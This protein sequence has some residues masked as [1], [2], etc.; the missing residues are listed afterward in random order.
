MG[1]ALTGGIRLSGWDSFQSARL[2][3]PGSTGACGQNFPGHD[4]LE[5]CVVPE[6]TGQVAGRERW[7]SQ[8]SLGGGECPCPLPEHSLKPERPSV[9]G[10]L[11]PT[12]IYPKRCE[13]R[14]QT[15]PLFSP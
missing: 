8:V 1:F 2:E 7:D 12:C 15:D 6:G 10:L 3:E 11:I 9:R 5:L 13:A 4:P 14:V